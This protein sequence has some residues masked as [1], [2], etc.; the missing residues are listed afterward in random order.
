VVHSGVLSYHA[1]QTGRTFQIKTMLS[2]SGSH[3]LNLTI[4]VTFVN[5]IPLLTLS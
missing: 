3:V 4:N 1:L 5:L 2:V